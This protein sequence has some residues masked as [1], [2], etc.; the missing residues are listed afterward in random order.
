MKKILVVDDEEEISN[1]LR[2]FLTI[3]GYDV[4]TASGG[5]EALE[6]TPTFG[7]DLILLD[8][9]MKDLDGIETLKKIK[10]GNPSLKVVMI[11]AVIDG[12]YLMEALKSGAEDYITKP[13]QYDY[14]E[15]RFARFL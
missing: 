6:K 4:E 8:I 1:V 2:H 9:W 5:L 7:P 12:E 3:K 13:F 14:L 15:E 11:T 10:S